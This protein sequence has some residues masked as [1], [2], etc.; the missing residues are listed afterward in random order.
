MISTVITI[1]AGLSSE[2]ACNGRYRNAAELRLFSLSALLAAF[3][4]IRR[5]TR[6][7]VAQQYGIPW[8]TWA[9]RRTSVVGCCTVMLFG[10]RSSV[11]LSLSLP[12][13]LFATVSPFPSILLS[14]SRC[15]IPSR[16]AVLRPLLTTRYSSCSRLYY[17]PSSCSSPSL[18]S[19]LED[20]LTRG[21]RVSRRALWW[22]LRWL[23]ASLESSRESVPPEGQGTPSG[24]GSPPFPPL[25]TPS[26]SSP[27]PP[28]SLSF[29]FPLSSLRR[30]SL[31]TRPMPPPVRTLGFYLFCLITAVGM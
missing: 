16:F 19:R 26:L 28:L 27:P 15:L 11:V 23:L 3:S 20:L 29:S 1:A 2:R 30:A 10:P 13:P 6:R 18:H 12:S 14:F 5:R 25:S 9:D 31:P 21:P 8:S 4:W 17:S 24:T 7:V 22:L